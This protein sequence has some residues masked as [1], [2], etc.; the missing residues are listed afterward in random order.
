MNNAVAVAGW[1]G[2]KRGNNLRAA[3]A[4][5]FERLTIL[6][7]ENS[8]RIT[9]TWKGFLCWRAWGRCTVVL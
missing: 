7:A 6:S 4:E 9:G 2:A 3:I 1:R 5:G 8:Y